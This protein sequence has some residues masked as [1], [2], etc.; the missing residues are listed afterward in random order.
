M[1]IISYSKFHCLK[2]LNDYNANKR[3]RTVIVVCVIL[4]P[5]FE[6]FLILVC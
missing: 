4:E 6:R 3:N 2:I 5:N 1:I